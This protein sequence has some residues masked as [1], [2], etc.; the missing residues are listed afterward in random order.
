MGHSGINQR[1]NATHPQHWM[2]NLFYYQLFNLMRGL[3][4]KG[5]LI[6]MDF[7]EVVPER[8]LAN[9]TSLFAARQLLNFIGVV[10][11]SKL[12][13]NVNKKSNRK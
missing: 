3:A 6:G 9:L 8:D 13:T 1:P 12:S 11:H 2:I 7:V 5:A 4:G 10:A